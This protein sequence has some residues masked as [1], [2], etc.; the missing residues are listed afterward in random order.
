M[1]NHSNVSKLSDIISNFIEFEIEKCKK[2]PYNHNPTLGDMYEA[3]TE[4]AIDQIIPV[5]FNLKIVSGFIYDEYGFQSRQID[6]ML[7]V[8]DGKRIGRTNSYEYNINDVLVIFEVKKSLNKNELSDAY[9]L[10]SAISRAYKNSFEARISNK[11]EINIMYAAKSFSQITGR[12][13]PAEYY[14]IKFMNQEEALIFYTL[15]RDTYAP[16]SIVHGYGGYKTE[17]GLRDSFISF[18][19]SKINSECF[20][21][22]CIPN[23]TSSAP[24]SIVKTTGM[25][26]KAKLIQEDYWPIV[27][28]TRT[29]TMYLMIEIIWTKLSLVF[30][31]RMPWGIDLESDVM[32]LLLSG[33][34]ACNEENNSEGWRYK[35]ES[36]QENELKDNICKED[37][38]PPIVPNIFY[39]LVQNISICGDLN[40]ESEYFKC[41]VVESSRSEEEIIK[42]L[43]GTNILTFDKN[44]GNIS[45]IGKEL[46]FV[47]VS[48]NSWAIYDDKSRLSQWCKLKGIEPNFINVYR[49]I[50]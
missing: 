24:F 18:L 37:W 1:A 10:L 8:G 11:D 38:E 3:I 16:I 42:E 44:T 15:V 33:K 46:Y 49:G 32:A 29:N 34:Y 36:I 5:K 35:F 2:F 21:T 6:R 25:P 20:G 12:P 28:S 48:D 14:D 22:P 50:N 9:E 30:N 27:S 26:F 41:H 47:Q 13:E 31:Y 4:G 45:I 17:K 39:K 23:L 7:V 19:K 43:I 40:V